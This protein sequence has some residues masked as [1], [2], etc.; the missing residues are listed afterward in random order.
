MVSGNL[1]SHLKYS[2]YKSL[3]ISNQYM[4]T[5]LTKKGMEFRTRTLEIVIS[6]L[7]G[8]YSVIYPHILYGTLQDQTTIWV[9]NMWKLRIGSFLQILA[10]LAFDSLCDIQGNGF[11]AKFELN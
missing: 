6:V 5:N 4:D 2:E 3:Q 7:F 11:N 8:Q 10:H 1:L 9:P